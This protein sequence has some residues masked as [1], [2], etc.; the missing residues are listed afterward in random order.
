MEPYV[1]VF[2]VG[3]S[4]LKAV[5]YDKTGAVIGLEQSRYEYQTPAPRW[6]ETDPWDW[7]DGL[8][9]C[10]DAMSDSYDLH[11][12]EAISFTGQMHTVVMLD[13]GLE[14][15]SPTILWL[16]RRAEAETLELSQRFG[17]PPYVLNSTYSL[18]KIYWIHRNRPE[19]MKKTKTI[20]WAKDYLRF[21]M[22]GRVATDA[23][24][25]IGAALLDWGTGEWAAQ[26]LVDI[27]VSP[28]ILPEMLPAN[29]V[30]G[31]LHAPVAE[32][33]GFDPLPSDAIFFSFMFVLA[34]AIERAG[35][36]DRAAIA[37]VIR[38]TKGLD[39]VLGPLASDEKGEMV[40]TATIF[41]NV[42][43]VA[44]PLE[45]VG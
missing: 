44:K 10:L 45:R 19:Q 31:A 12:V 40:H 18:P 11:K 41:Q 36:A 21:A 4:S 33:Y 23:T 16:D 2:D 25:G 20:L 37:S 22:T 28:D 8:W 38:S 26:R 9:K 42:G 15:L 35:V 17:L 34:D 5:L 6:A 14:P 13:E 29:A 27:G 24:E 43:K 39:S 30:A 7:L 32:K 1:L 3:T